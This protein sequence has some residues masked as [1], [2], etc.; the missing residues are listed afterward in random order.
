MKKPIKS[1]YEN[2]TDFSLFKFLKYLHKDVGD[3][4]EYEGVSS[5]DSIAD[6]VVEDSLK[7]FGLSLE[8]VDIDFFWV[9]M[10]L[11]WDNLSGHDKLDFELKKPEVSEY[12]IE[13]K[14]SGRNYYTEYGSQT[15][16]AYSTESAEGY[17][18][19]DNFQ[20]FEC[21][22]WYDNDVHDS[23][24]DDWEIDSIEPVKNYNEMSEQN[25]IIKKL[26]KENFENV[27]SD[28]NMDELIQMRDIIVE[29]LKNRISFI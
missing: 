23:Q 24:T 11:N 3:I 1:K 9:A 20:A 6:N 16:S 10:K 17:T 26:L 5:Y 14:F 7:K 25:T 29:K 28:Y 12:K 15:I 2:L 4:S 13:I 19:S 27:V 18:S 8:L 22:D 21:D